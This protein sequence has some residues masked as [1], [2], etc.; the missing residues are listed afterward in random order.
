MVD[1][2]KGAGCQ[3]KPGMTQAAG[4]QVKPGM[5]RESGVKHES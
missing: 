3:V 2:W 1:A 4:C 5:T